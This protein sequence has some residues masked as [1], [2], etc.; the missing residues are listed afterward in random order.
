MIKRKIVATGLAI[1]I[2]FSSVPSTGYAANEEGKRLEVIGKTE[3]KKGSLGMFDKDSLGK[4]SEIVGSK[5]FGPEDEVTVIVELEKDSLLDA[6]YSVEQI[7][8]SRSAEKY[9]VS[10]DGQIKTVTKR[11]EATLKEDMYVIY[12]YKVAITGV[13]IKT[14]YQNLDKIEKVKGVKSAW[15]SP[16][17]YLSEVDTKTSNSVGMIGA[18]TIWNTK[19]YTG[20]GMKIAI[21]DTGIYADHDSFK[22]LSK[23]QLTDDSMVGSD[24]KDVW[25]QLNAAKYSDYSTAAYYNSKIPY[26]YNYAEHNFDVSHKYSDHGTHVAGIA[27]ANKID[28]TEVVG[29]A[30]DAQLIVMQVFAPTGG[31]DFID[32]LAAME[33]AVYLDV[34]V[35]NLSLGATS[36][37]TDSEAEINGICDKFAQTDIQV[38]IAAGNETHNGVYNNYGYGFSLASDP[39]NGLIGTP[40]TYTEAMTIASLDNTATRAD[41]FHVGGKAVTYNDTATTSYTKWITAL[42]TMKDYEY[43]WVG[44][45]ILGGSVDDFKNANHGAGVEGKIALVSRGE[46]AFA[47]KQANAAKAGAIACIVYNNQD[48]VISMQ[49]ND[50]KDNIP[51]VSITKE[52][53]N[54][55]ISKLTNGVGNL[56]TGDGEPIITIG[57]TLVMSDFS[58]WGVTPSLHLKPDVT[59]VGGNVYSTRDQNTYGLMSGTSMATPQIAGATALIMQ[60]IKETYGDTLTP[61]QVRDLTSALLMSAASPVLNNDIEYSPR[62]QGAGFVNLTDTLATKGYLTSTEQVDGRPKAELGDSK[63]GTY[64]FGFKVNN[65][66]EDYL[67]YEFD[68]SLL[69]EGVGSDGKNYFMLSSPE[70]L[71][72][73]V[74]FSYTESLKYDFN[75]DG[76]LTTADVRILILELNQV[77]DASKRPEECMDVNGDGTFDKKDS[78][79]LA[80][81]IAEYEVNFNPDATVAVVPANGTLACEATIKLEED[82]KAYMDQYFENGIYVE[83][84]VYAKSLNGDVKELSMPVLG[85]YGDWTDAPVF[86]RANYYQYEMDGEYS[87]YPIIMYTDNSVLGANPYIETSYRSEHNAVS[88][89]NNLNEIDIGLLRNA[90]TLKFTVTN[91]KTKEVYWT[92]TEQDVP[93]SYYVSEYGQ[94]VPYFI[95]NEEGTTTPTLWDGTDSAG[96]ILADNTKVMLKVEAKVDYEGDN[97]YQ[98]F[99]VPIWVDNA[100]PEVKILDDAKA[101]EKDGKQM[102]QLEVSDNCYI[103]SVAIK[104]PQGEVI[105]QIALEDYIPGTVEKCEIDITGAGSNF[106]VVVS[107]YAC[108]QTTYGINE[109]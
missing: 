45:G 95:Y 105:R 13:A 61:Q 85:F 98:S 69:T 15:V 55:L 8:E 103:A 80:S 71:S 9:L 94:I 10:Q 89:V 42:G 46:V 1:L 50:G 93:K 53:G 101:V 17:F 49:I 86:D 57:N 54:Y 65:L 64:R 36:G 106:N 96:N 44:E 41:V 19:G 6:G 51:C 84:F 33:D 74:S 70:A 14:Q 58:S 100:A 63:T 92:Y 59:G 3:D 38:S 104:N 75:H 30:P 52:E 66:S 82:D 108:N 91:E 81:Y 102:L 88:K 24:V 109:N 79:E 76:K 77:T 97:Q 11:L 32:I 22:A 26:A 5:A 87:L 23:E 29:V 60:Y 107:D 28:T 16:I 68:S 37:F 35:M 31:A 2:A 56:S 67:C 73:K 27:A 43:V 18:N 78:V 48:G 39:D 7:A 72:S 83:G 40:G 90:K 20:K 25:S 34:D 47:D 12:E 4:A 21:L 99:E 62:L